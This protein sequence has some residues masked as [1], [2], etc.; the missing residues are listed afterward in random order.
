MTNSNNSLSR[1][2]FFRRSSL[3]T[4]G[5]F[6]ETA[7]LSAVPLISNGTT[8]KT[9]PRRI[10]GKIRVPVSTLS[11]DTTP[12]GLTKDVSAGQIADIVDRALD[13]GINFIDTAHTVG[14][15]EEG[16]GMVLGRRRREFFLSTKIWSDTPS[17]AERSLAAS[18]R[19]LKTDYVD[20]LYFHRELLDLAGRKLAVQWRPHFAPIPIYTAR[21]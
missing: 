2:D 11:I 16:I 13:Q 19:S 15:A 17:D 12:C 20:L 18:L 14:K 9:I 6:L 8:K 10:L 3:I 4:G 21:A 1:R 7:R 5:L